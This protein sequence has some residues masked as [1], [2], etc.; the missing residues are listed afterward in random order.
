MKEAVFCIKI[1]VIRKNLIYE[2]FLKNSENCTK[3]NFS[4]VCYI[5]DEGANDVV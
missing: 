5:S 2:I 1:S 3:K 4:F